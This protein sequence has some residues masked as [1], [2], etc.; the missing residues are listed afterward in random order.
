MTVAM[1]MDG[2]FVPSNS[3]FDHTRNKILVIG[4][5][6]KFDDASFSDLSER[7]AMGDQKLASSLT[8]TLGHSLESD[9]SMI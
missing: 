9:K 4:P 3:T 1:S 2:W 7:L 8:K 5:P 6:S